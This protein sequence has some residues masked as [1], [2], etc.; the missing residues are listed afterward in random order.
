MAVQIPSWLAIDPIEPARLAAASAAR[1]QQAAIAE[2]AAQLR[3][4]EMELRAQVEQA[5][6]AQQERAAYRRQIMAEQLAQA[7]GQRRA[8]DLAMRRELHARQASQFQQTIQMRQQ[9]AERA[10]AESAIQAEGSRGLQADLDQGIP[11]EQALPKHAGKLFYKHPERLVP[12]MRAVTPPGEPRFGKTPGGAEYVQDPRGGVHFPPGMAAGPTGPVR[13]EQ[14]VDE[15][16]NPIGA[17]VIRGSRGGI[18]MMPQERMTPAARVSA[19]KARLS[20]IKSDMLMVPEAEMPALR[21]QRDSILHELE[22]I[23][24]T[25]R[26]PGKL[27]ESLPPEEEEAPMDEAAPEGVGDE[28][29]EEAVPVDEEEMVGDEE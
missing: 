7:E 3:Q 21:R 12:A 13:A 15:Q 2:R 8:E 4:Q 26:S 17:Q 24:T 5:H 29:D 16:G 1:R 10:A 22:Q 25:P 9:A 11:L 18:H 23:S 14:V 19:L 6:I 20:A 27:D 28:G